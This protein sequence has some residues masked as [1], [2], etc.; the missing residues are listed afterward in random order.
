MVFPPRFIVSI[1]LT[2]RNEYF[3]QLFSKSDPPNTTFRTIR[4]C[5][6]GFK[7]EPKRHAVAYMNVW[8]ILNQ[9][10]QI[11]LCDKIPFVWRQNLYTNKRIYIL[12][13]FT[14]TMR[15]HE[16]LWWPSCLRYMISSLQLCMLLSFISFLTIDRNMF[17]VDRLVY[18][19]N[20]GRTSSCT[21]TEKQLHPYRAFHHHNPQGTNHVLLHQDYVSKLPRWQRTTSDS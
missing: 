13:C 2:E 16:S 14:L 11:K 19:P 1:V 17:F 21:F 3:Q 10:F 18:H 6:E 20:Y 9:T 5:Y 7:K 4:G 12:K 15:Y 8:W